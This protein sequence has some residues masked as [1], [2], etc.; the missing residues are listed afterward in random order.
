MDRVVPE[1]P[2]DRPPEQS[3]GVALGEYMVERRAALGI[4]QEQLLSRMGWAVERTW[5]LNLENGRRKRLPGQPY[6][7][8]L[9]KALGVTEHEL[10]RRSGVLT[11]SPDAQERTAGRGE[12]AAE[13][14][15]REALAGA[16]EEEKAALAGVVLGWRDSLKR[17]ARRRGGSGTSGGAVRLVAGAVA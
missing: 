12:T 16:A 14:K 15:L 13:V 7:G 1:A 10:L 5:V 2:D 3:H 6:L 8:I 4:T 9:A 11:G 17:A